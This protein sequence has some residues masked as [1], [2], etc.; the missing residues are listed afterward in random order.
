MRRTGCPHGLTNRERAGVAA[1]LP[2][3]GGS[4]PPH[5]GSTLSCTGPQPNRQ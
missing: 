4:G 5:R 2:D 3:G 1:R